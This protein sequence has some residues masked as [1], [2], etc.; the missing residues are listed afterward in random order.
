MPM[1]QEGKWQEAVYLLAQMR[2]GKAL[3]NDITC[4]MVP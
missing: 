4:N 2:R 1:E 3:P